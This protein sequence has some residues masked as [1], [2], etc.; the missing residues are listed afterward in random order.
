VID[1]VIQLLASGLLVGGMY[2]LTATGLTLVMGVMRLVNVAHGVFF[3]LGGYLTFA[4]LSLLGLN[5]FLA[6]PLAGVGAGVVAA[7]VERTMVRRVRRDEL[8]VVILTL[9]LAFVGQEALR[10][11]FGGKP[12]SLPA[13]TGQSLLIGSVSLEGQ[14]VVVFGLALVLIAALYLLVRYTRWGMALRMVAQDREAALLVGINT[15]VVFML[16]FGI[17]ALVAGLAGGLMGPINLISPAMGWNPLLVSF[18]AV[19]LGGMGSIWGTVLAGLLL[20][21]IELFSGFFINPSMGT[22]S[23]LLVLIAVVVARPTGLFGQD[24]RGG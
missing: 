22:I 1:T 20:G 3:T 16:T 9:A 24:V 7:L 8:R 5:F 2:A 10:V 21:V 12:K 18:A 13:F 4:G 17:G 11:I 19:V 6:V 14:R 15:D 23:S